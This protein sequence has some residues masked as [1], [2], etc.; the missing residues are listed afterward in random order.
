VGEPR[1]RRWFIVAGLTMAAVAVPVVSDALPASTDAVDP[2]RLRDLMLRSADLPHQG[3]AESSGRLALPELP[4]LASVTALLTG[5]TKMRTWYAARDRYRFDVLAL[6]GEQDVYRTPD[7]EHIWDSA[8]NKITQVFADMPV[9]LPRAGDLL[10]P[11]LAR[12]ILGSAPDDAVTAIDARRVAGMSAAGLRLVPA[13]PDTTIGHVDIWADPVRG[14]PLRVELTAKDAATPVIMSRFLDVSLDPP[15]ADVLTH[16]IPPGAGVEAVDVP[17]I[18]GVLASFGLTTPPGRLAGR[19]LRT[20]AL[21]GI[22][23]VGLYGSGLSSFVVLQLPR[24]VANSAIDAATKAGAKE[25]DDVF[26]LEIAPLSLAVMRSNRARRSYLLAGLVSPK[27]LQ[28][29]GAELSVLPR[30][31]R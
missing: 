27:V 31:S 1:N 16:K 14:L 28:R 25:V 13:D 29:A 3:Y 23:G 11:D 12:R 10:P 4:K 20:D 6:A 21:A 26:Q 22:P 8:E 19:D 5:T 7:Y 17:D 24:D 2:A 15:T 30:G 9:R 18:S